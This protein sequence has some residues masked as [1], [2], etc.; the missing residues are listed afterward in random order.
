MKKIIIFAT[1]ILLGGVSVKAQ[2]IVYDPS[3]N[4]QTAMNQAQNM[5]RYVEMIDNQIQQI[6]TLTSQLQEIQQYRQAFGDP[7]KILSIVGVDDLVQDLQKTGLGKSMD[8]IQNLS[9]GIDALKYDA[10]G[11]YHQIGDTFSTPNGNLMPRQMDDYRPFAAVNQTTRNYSE[12]YADVLTRRKA[13]KLNIASTTAKLQSATTVAETQKLTG[14]LIG[15]NSALNATDK[16]LDQALG[17]AWVQDS[18]NRN[19]Q[20]KQKQARAEEQE[21]EFSEATQ[22]FG[23]T[24]KLSVETPSFQEDSHEE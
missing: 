15:L 4:N 17:L 16:E 12:V 8:S 21:L 19:D 22:K 6:H 18:E 7:S 2:Y 13:L 3:L 14:V 9:Q 23:S 11:L 10:K 1:G 24:M 20:Q 5:A